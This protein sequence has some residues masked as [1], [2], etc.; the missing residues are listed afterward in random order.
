MKTAQK[1][2]NNLIS[3]TKS[4]NILFQLQLQHLIIHLEEGG[5]FQDLKGR[6]TFSDLN[7]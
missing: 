5:L 4:Y 3:H 6:L 7:C 1:I 2:V